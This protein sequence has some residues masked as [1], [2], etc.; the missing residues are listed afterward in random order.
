[1]KDIVGYVQQ[2][3]R[4]IEAVK[5]NK[6]KAKKEMTHVVEKTCQRLDEQA[7]DRID[8]LKG[9]SCMPCNIVHTSLVSWQ[10]ITNCSSAE[11]HDYLC[12]QAVEITK[13]SHDL[14]KT[15]TSGNVSTLVNSNGELKSDVSASIK[16]LLTSY[17]K[18][19]ALPTI[20]RFVK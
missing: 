14:E 19:E 3:E 8:L 18:M 17:H 12:N 16:Q 10:A 7:K 20:A 1:M 5:V 9:M 11:F 4:K 13:E 6:S 15:I 2:V